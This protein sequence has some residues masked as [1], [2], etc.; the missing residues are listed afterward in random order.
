MY[1]GMDFEQNVLKGNGVI[2]LLL[3]VWNSG[4]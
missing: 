2:L 3:L 4:T 1:T